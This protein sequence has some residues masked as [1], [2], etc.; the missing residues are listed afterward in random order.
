MERNMREFI[1]LSRRVLRNLLRLKG[2]LDSPEYDGTKVLLDS[3]EYE[4]AKALLDEMIEDTQK[5][6]EA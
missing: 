2:L 4:E 3:Q 6:T 5:D 1:A